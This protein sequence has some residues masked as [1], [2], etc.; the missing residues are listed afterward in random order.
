M[1]GFGRGER[2]AVANGLDFRSDF[3]STVAN[4]ASGNKPCLTDNA[5]LLANS[6]L[7]KVVFISKNVSTT[8]AVID[9]PIAQ[10]VSIDEIIT[11]FIELVNVLTCFISI[12]FL[13]L[14][15]RFN[16]V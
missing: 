5:S 13:L 1:E 14:I 12:S 6:L 15:F 7:A 3:V 16:I 10:I 9:V 4:L 11:V 2:P 8:V